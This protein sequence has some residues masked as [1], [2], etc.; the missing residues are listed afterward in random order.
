VGASREMVNRV[1]KELTDG[2]YIAINK[3]VIFLKRKLP[4]KF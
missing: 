2:S 1:L 3:K 4:H